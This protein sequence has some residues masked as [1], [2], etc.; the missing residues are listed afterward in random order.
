M[1][2]INF[3]VYL[4]VQLRSVFSEYLVFLIINLCKLIFVNKTNSDSSQDVGSGVGVYIYL[5]F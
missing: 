3:K 1:G 4:R 5:Y 2:S